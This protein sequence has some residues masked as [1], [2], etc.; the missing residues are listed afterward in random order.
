[1]VGIDD[2]RDPT[3]R[4][5]VDG[6]GAREGIGE[7]D[8]LGEVL[9]RISLTSSFGPRGGG[10]GTGRLA[11]FRPDVQDRVEAM[12]VEILKEKVDCRLDVANGA[13]GALYFTNFTTIG[14][15]TR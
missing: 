6:Q 10:Q 5:A 15:I 8:G 1:M 7:V 3:D 4:A 11:T 14:R 2:D 13:D 12:N 9:R